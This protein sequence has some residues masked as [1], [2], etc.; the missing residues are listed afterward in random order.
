MQPIIR[1]IDVGYS[2]VK[3]TTGSEANGDP[4]CRSFP[5]L[6]PLAS[7][8]QLCAGPFEKRDSVRVAVNGATYEVGPDA[9]L[10][11][12]GHFATVRHEAF[13]QT[14]S[15]RALF[16]GTLSYMHLPRIDTLVL[17]LPVSYL[18]SKLSSLIEL[19]KGTH[20]LPGDKTVVIDK[21]QVFGQPVG[22]YFNFLHQHGATKGT[23]KKTLI[24]DPG[25][26]TLDWIV[27]SGAKPN[28]SRSGSFQGGVSSIL[29]AIQKM[30]A[31]DGIPHDDMWRLNEGLRTGSFRIYGKP[32]DLRPYLVEAQPV[33]IEAVDMMLS[34]IG[35]LSD[36]DRVLLVGGGASL[37]RPAIEARANG[38][39]V[40]Q[41][42]AP[43]FA[44]VRGFQRLA[45]YVEKR[46]SA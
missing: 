37:Y 11:L 25:Y 19:A 28:G 7:D 45:E 5:S 41:D 30:L 21:V 29:A 33:I 2:N 40:I 39:E 23:K 17:G 10:A 26:V 43:E 12:K 15:Y 6:T 13:C 8:D 9:Y 32:V 20:Q 44:N 27:A 16:L 35:S 42:T 18:G 3:F 34:T 36:I 14:D 24:V 46:K 4:I 1:A 38:L 31:R 22:G